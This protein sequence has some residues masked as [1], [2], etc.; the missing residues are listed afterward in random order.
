[1]IIKKDLI[2][3]ILVVDD[4]AENLFAMEKILNLDFAL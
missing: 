2:A 1:M 3:K 4:R